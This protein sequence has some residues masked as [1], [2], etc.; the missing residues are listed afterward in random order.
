MQ[1]TTPPELSFFERERPS[2]GERTAALALGS[3]QME[4]SGL[5]DPL[6]DGLL[7]RYAPYSMPAASAPDALR[8][9]L[10]REDEPEYFIRPQKRAEQSRVLLAYDRPTD[11]V[12]YVSYIV[13][14]WFDTELGGRG[15][16]LLARGTFEPPVRAMENYVRSAVAWQAAARGGALIHAASAVLEDRAFLFYGESGAGK[17]TLSACNRRARI[18]SDDLSL[19]LPGPDGRLHLVGSPFRG[20]YTEGPPVEGSWPLAA[21]FRIVKDAVAEVRSTSRLRALSELVGNLPFVADSLS[22]RPELFDRIRNSVAD[23]P[24]AHLHF[25]KDDSYWDAILAAGY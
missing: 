21:G 1:P 14:G 19:V 12:R 7:E 8:V 11:R 23:V 2:P 24:L 9:R 15:E 20:T 13:A 3:L 16:V 22:A 4:F 10:A 17:S 5:D 18:V 25:R 6:A